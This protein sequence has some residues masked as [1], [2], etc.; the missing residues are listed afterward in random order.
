MSAWLLAAACALAWGAALADSAPAELRE[1]RRLLE[2][3]EA[4][5]SVALLERSL[6]QYAGSADFD[7]LLGLALYQAGQ[8]GEALFALERVVMVD[9]GHLEARLKAAKIYAERGGAEQAEALLAPLTRQRLG[10]EQWR[11]VER[12]RGGLGTAT[13]GEGL[14]LRGYVLGGAGWDSNITSGPAHSELVIPYLNPGAST[15]TPL[16]GAAQ[17]RDLVGIAEVGVALRQALDATTWVSGGASLRQG[18]NR[19]RKDVN[20]GIANFDLGIL[21]RRGDDYWGATLLAQDY[22]SGDA[23]YRQALGGRLSWSHPLDGQARM[24]GYFQHVKFTYPSY[25]V[26]NANRQIAGVAVDAALR[27]GP[28]LLQYGLY[29]GQEDSQDNVA[30]HFSFRLWGVHA[31]AGM[32]LRDDLSLSIAALY[33][34]RHHVAEDPFYLYPR[35]DA[36]LSVGVSADYRVAGR[37]RLIPQYTFTRN[38]SNTELYDYSRNTFMLQL[39]WDFD[40]EKI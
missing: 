20:E 40:H 19:S 26:D 7:Y 8:P 33:E 17:D 9:A 11:E 12:I 24:S 10:A 14:S 23:L 1:A 28:Q 6:L 2:A 13:T 35:R 29:G 18:F 34:R 3:G 4:G 39:R 30:P 5:Q 16:G 31:R 38:A 37:W 22:L 27:P 15:T 25:P 32:P 21:T 36:Q